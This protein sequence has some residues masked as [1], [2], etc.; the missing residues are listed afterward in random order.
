MTTH[1]TYVLGK[2][3]NDEVVFL[4]TYIYENQKQEAQKDLKEIIDAGLV[5]KIGHISKIFADYELKEVDED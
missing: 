3:N 4:K 5:W 2:N 1:D